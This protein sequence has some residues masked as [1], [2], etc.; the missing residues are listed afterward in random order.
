MADILQIGRSGLMAARTAL[1]VTSENIAN[2][3]TP[4]YRRREAMQEEI[5]MRSPA[6]NLQTGTG[7]GA[8]V[9]GVR[10]AFDALLAART[11][12][13]TGAHAAAQTAQPYLEQL[14]LRLMPEGGG[15]G[16]ALD[17]FFAALGSLAA[18]PTDTGLR[19]VVIE[20]G[21]GLA[22]G[23]SNLAAS[24]QELG[25]GIDAESGQNVDRANQILTG[26]A[27]L[28]TAIR[29]EGQSKAHNGLLDRR[30]ALLEE[31]SGITAVNVQI[32]DNDLVTVR[33]GS[34][35]GGPLLLE[36]TQAARI[37]MQ[38]GGLIEVSPADPAGA[39]VARRTESGALHGLFMAAGSVAE[40]LGEVGDWAAAIAD[41][42][43]ALHAT[44]ADRN[45][46]PGGP[47]FSYDTATGRME[48]LIGDPARLA[49][50]SLALVEPATGN[51]GTG[52]VAL[53][54]SADPALLASALEL[55]LTDADSNTL[56]LFDAGG[57]Q[58]AS[59]QPDAAGQITLGPLALRVQGSLR[60]GDSFAIGAMP[61]NSTD[62]SVIG[63]LADLR[64]GDGAGG[65]GFGAIYAGV[66]ADVGAQVS[67]MRDRAAT[68]AAQRDSAQEAEAA[69]SAVDLDA[70]AARLVQQQQAYQA[71]ARVITVARELFDTLLATM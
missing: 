54:G 12:D 16:P 67:A 13:A 19:N 46:Q 57:A 26:L 32:H 33:L 23:V 39:T 24:L 51:D 58:I 31:L 21:K 28:Q 37:G 30:D 47:L 59:G 55:R 1:E 2:V 35:A 60:T 49:A 44:G 6:P 15:P 8:L 64:A 45:G 50:A 69:G 7:Q 43:A 36:G 4:G 38:P 63:A 61:A 62:G 52:Q 29:R 17:G 65:G 3:N 42:T 14:E 53:A 25:Q 10:R 66:V 11:R 18:T 22:Q 40:A 71:N 5:V 20:T 68:T 34:D 70:E 27:E 41:Q 56:A 48:F 9:T